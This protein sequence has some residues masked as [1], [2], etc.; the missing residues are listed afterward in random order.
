MNIR[1]PFVL[2]LYYTPIGMNPV[3]GDYP[4]AASKS[5]G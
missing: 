5:N 3:E 1:L 2:S 4:G